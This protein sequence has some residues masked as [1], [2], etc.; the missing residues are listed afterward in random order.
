M[1]AETREKVFQEFNTLS[2]V[3]KQPSSKFVLNARPNLI[4]RME[5]PAP[6]DS[7]A[8]DEMD[9]MD[10]MS[11]PVPIGTSDPVSETAD[12]LGEALDSAPAQPP[13]P[14]A[15]SVDL[16][17]MGD[18]LG[19]DVAT[20]TSFNFTPVERSAPAVPQFSLA[21]GVTMT[22]PQFEAN[23]SRL[24]ASSTYAIATRQLPQ[25][26]TAMVE[27]VLRQR[28]INVVASGQQGQSLK[29]FFYAK[30][31][32]GPAAANLSGDIWF[33]IEMSLGVAAG[34]P[35]QCTFK[36]DNAQASSV[37]SFVALVFAALDAYVYRC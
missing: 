19:G 5:P 32:T 24:P 22:G 14:P 10:S 21:S 26:T 11:M 30:Q 1:D 33:L 2:I 23:W 37:E 8:I 35:G 9:G 6:S 12:L 31:A 17:S 13:P 29:F 7:Y 34:I 27:E 16:L 4:T 36:A 20:D 18:L 3:F 15:P 25:L 28:G